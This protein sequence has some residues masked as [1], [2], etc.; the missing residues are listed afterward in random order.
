MRCIFRGCIGKMSLSRSMLE[1]V[2]FFFLFLHTVDLRIRYVCFLIGL[3]PGFLTVS[4]VMPEAT[5][6]NKLNP[7]TRSK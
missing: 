4:G 3:S 2:A 5:N 6:T 7:A 1:V